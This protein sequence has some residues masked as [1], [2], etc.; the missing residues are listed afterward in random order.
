MIKDE[1]LVHDFTYHD[2]DS[3]KAQAYQDIRNNALM[4]SRLIN[5]ICPDSREKSLAITN[6]EQAVMWANASIARN[7]E[8]RPQR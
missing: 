4:L 5:I 2:S 8:G 6:I 7:I 3:E 1:S